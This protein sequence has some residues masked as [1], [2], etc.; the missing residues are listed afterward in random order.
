VTDPG[1]A[2]SLL[3]LVLVLTL[4]PVPA[5]AEDAPPTVELWTIGTGEDLYARFG[6][7]A[8]RVAR[9]GWTDRV[10]NYGTTDFSRPDLVT[11]F[12]TGEAEFWLGVSTGD[13]SERIYRKVDRSIVVDELLLPPGA[14][15]ELA[16][17]L[18]A[19]AD[20]R[21]A[22]TYQYHHFLDNCA[23]RARDRIDVASGGALRAVADRW[24]AGP[25]FRDLARAG[26]ADMPWLLV[27]VDLLLGRPA[28]RQADPWEEMFLPATLQRAVLEAEVVW[29]DGAT[30]PLAGAQRVL[31]EREGPPV[32][33]ADPGL[34]VRMTWLVA[35]A[36]ALLALAR[37]LAGGRPRRIEGLLLLV[38]GLLGGLVAVAVDVVAWMS[39]QHEVRANETLLW[40][41]PLDLWLVVPGVALLLRRRGMLR[42]VKWYAV[43]RGGA[44]ALA[45][46]AHLPGWLIQPQLHLMV[47]WLAGWGLV[48]ATLMHDSASPRSTGLASPAEEPGRR[49]P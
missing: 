18:H 15:H 22:S 42:W 16:R 1:R 12:M 38:A 3:A 33:D 13:R 31:Y 10:Y 44:L 29:P 5:S 4:V 35:A 17:A 39:I 2:P 36:L 49:T 48:W 9:P 28:D 6:H 26:F 37:G 25:T 20:D 24:Q 23:T 30:R 43:V 8:I 34:P 14:A 11:S 45:L 27:G 40:A 32:A 46:A 41:W 19:E 7:T 47:A 21:E